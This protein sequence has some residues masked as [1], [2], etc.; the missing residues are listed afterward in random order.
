MTQHWKLLSPRSRL[1]DGMGSIKE[2]GREGG[3]QI[4]LLRFDQVKGPLLCAHTCS[5]LQGTGQQ[6]QQ[7]GWM[8]HF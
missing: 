6:A 1:G 8:E 5:S 4:E 7:Q 3:V 2:R